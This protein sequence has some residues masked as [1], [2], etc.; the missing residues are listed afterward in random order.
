MT[1]IIGAQIAPVGGYIGSF[2]ITYILKDKK[3]Q[4]KK[5]KFISNKNLKK[6]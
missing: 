3:F 2:Y 4:L 1:A 5:I 6:P